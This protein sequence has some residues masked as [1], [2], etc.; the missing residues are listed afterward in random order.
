VHLSLNTHRP[1]SLRILNSVCFVEDTSTLA[2]VY[3]LPKEA[4]PAKQPASLHNLLENKNTMMRA[5][6]LEDRLEMAQQLANTIY[7]FGLIRWFHKDFSSHNVI[8]FWDKSPRARPLLNAPWVVGFSIAR[9]EREGEK[10]LNKALDALDIYMHPDLRVEDAKDRPAYHRK[11]EMYS[12]GLVL[13]EIGAWRPLD[14]I[15]DKG[16]DAVAFKERVVDR[17]T[18]DLGFFAGSKYRDIVLYCL[19][20]ADDEHDDMSSLDALYWSVV[21]EIARTR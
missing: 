12:L 8:F 21:L 3:Q 11:Y 13:F 17:C 19:T 18:K 14:T 16:L 6:N 9:P 1:E 5:P 10:S 4:N 7:S 15:A 2:L 20:C